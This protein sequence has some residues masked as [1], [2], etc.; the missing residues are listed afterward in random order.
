MNNPYTAIAEA[1]KWEELFYPYRKDRKRRSSYY[2]GIN[3]RIEKRRKKNR[4]AR[5]A[6]KIN[7]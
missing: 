7:R 5:K 3:K 1:I 6:R 2:E 4:L